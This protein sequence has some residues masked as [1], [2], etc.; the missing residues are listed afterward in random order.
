MLRA[1]IT[2]DQGELTPRPIVAGLGDTGV[3]HGAEI[4]AF[5]DSVVLRDEYEFDHA[6]AALEERIGA[7]ATDRVAMVAGNFSMMNR[8]LDA[9]GAPVHRGLDDLAAEMGLTIPPH[10]AAP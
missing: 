10:L 7:A 5:V 1:S 2:T 4:M 8:A 9:V 6:R 3:N